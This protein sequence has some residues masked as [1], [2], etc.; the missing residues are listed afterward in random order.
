MIPHGSV[1]EAA[2]VAMLATTFGERE[3]RNVPLTKLHSDM[4]PIP[5]LGYQVICRLDSNFC[6]K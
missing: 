3:K 4:M 2:V 5:V 1:E 6:R